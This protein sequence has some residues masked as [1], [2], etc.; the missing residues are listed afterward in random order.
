[1]AKVDPTGFDKAIAAIQ[2]GALSERQQRI[3]TAMA[4]VREGHSI[5]KASK[6]CELPY[7]TLWG[8]CRGVSNLGRENDGGRGRDLDALQAASLDAS[9]IAVEK[10]RTALLTEDW[11]HGDLVK[12]YGVATDK[13]IAFSQQPTGE[14]ED[15]QSMLAKFLAGHKVTIEPKRAGD[16][17]IE[18]EGQGD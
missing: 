12:A 4:M 18:V 8:Y 5:L 1:M 14:A 11:K 7:S 3:A 15:G 9:L 2:P 10:L 13:V 17:A 16:D 6:E